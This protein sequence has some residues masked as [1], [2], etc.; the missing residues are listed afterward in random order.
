MKQRL[1]SAFILVSAIMFVNAQSTEK[2]SD[3]SK[4]SVAVKA[5]GDYFNIRPLGT[6][7][8]DNASWGAGLSLERTVNPFWGYGLNLDLL[9]YDR[10]TIKGRTIDPTLFAS[11]N[12]S[13][14]LIPVREASKF[15]VYAN[16]GAGASFNSYKD[17]I[18]H[19]GDTPEDDSKVTPVSFTALALEYNISEALALGVEGGYRGYVSTVGSR[20]QYDDAYTLMGVLRLKLGAKSK[21]HVR[22][23]SRDDFYGP[24]EAEKE[25][26]PIVQPYDDSKVLS[27][28]KDN[29]KEIDDL[30]NS[31]NKLQDEL[32]GLKENQKETPASFSLDNIQFKHDSSELME[33]AVPVLDEVASVLAKNADWKTLLVKGH[34]DNLGAEEYNQKLSENRA[35]SVKNYL[36]SKGLDGA[37]IVTTGCGEKQPICTNET[38]EGRQKNRR[39]E[40]EIVKK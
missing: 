20:L 14:I 5:G 32:K 1:L 37:S 23:M 16:F 12:L 11:L 38:T 22:N 27:Q 9:N 4:W 8:S 2:T 31:L 30:K 18:F 7:I 3:L 25:V 26:A 39:V 19:P 13:N 6:S 29:D 36:V 15:N 10:E 33:S 24:A 21:K 40:F 28:V 34:T 35:L 17:A